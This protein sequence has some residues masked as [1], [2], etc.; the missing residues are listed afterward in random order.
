MRVRCLTCDT[1]DIPETEGLR[2]GDAV[3]EGDT[4]INDHISIWHPNE[5]VRI[6]GIENGVWEIRA[7]GEHHV[8]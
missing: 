3:I 5:Y 4:T 7:T 2:R 1:D 8:P 6:E